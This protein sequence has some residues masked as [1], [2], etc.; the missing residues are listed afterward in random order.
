MSSPN[1]GNHRSDRFGKSE[2]LRGCPSATLSQRLCCLASN[3][4]E[5]VDFPH[6]PLFVLYSTRTL[7]IRGLTFFDDL[8]VV[9]EGDPEPARESILNCIAFTGR[10]LWCCRKPSL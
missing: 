6:A 5:D 9:T 2:P 7:S 4:L 3:P 1:K 8:E 10:G